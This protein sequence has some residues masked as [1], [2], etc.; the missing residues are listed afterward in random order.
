MIYAIW[1]QGDF[2]VFCYKWN[3]NEPELSSVASLEPEKYSIINLIL[4]KFRGWYVIA[5]NIS[6]VRTSFE[7][8][9]IH[10]SG[11]QTSNRGRIM[12]MDNIL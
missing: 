1:Y 10:H 5:V 12:A 2:G 11:G 4:K 9:R 7:S 6:V 3:Q 8:W